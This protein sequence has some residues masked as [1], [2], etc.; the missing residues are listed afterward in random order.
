MKLTK[1]RFITWILARLRIDKQAGPEGKAPTHG[2]DLGTGPPERSSSART[3]A[4]L[5]LVR[6]RMTKKAIPTATI[7]S[8]IP[9]LESHTASAQPCSSI[10]P[11]DAAI[12]V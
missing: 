8:V 12:P 4:H 11:S 9:M 2:G 6:M 3:R 10:A 1:N 5:T 7:T